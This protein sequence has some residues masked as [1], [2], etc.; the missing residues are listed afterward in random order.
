MR[1]VEKRQAED[2]LRQHYRRERRLAEEPPGRAE[3]VAALAAAEAARAA[4][5]TSRKGGFV[6]AAIKFSPR[7]FWAVPAVVVVLSLV[8]AIA[9][10]SAREAEAALVSSGPVLVAACLVG[11]VR[12]R[13]CRM[14]ELEASCPRNAVSVACARLAILGGATLLA[15]A[16]A[17]A[18]SWAVVPA[19]A[20]MAYALAPYLISAAGGLMLA[21]RVAAA[22]AAV[23]TVAWSAGVC[24]LCLLLRAALPGAYEAGALGMWAAVS[25][26]GAIWLAREAVGWLRLCA[27]GAAA[28]WSAA[29]AGA[30]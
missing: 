8:L 16:F 9:G 15:L 7:A 22:D 5:R 30:L 23:A 12:A 19:G 20:A 17:C 26:A 21:R 24:A 3:V 6:R 18:A 11:V 28:S 25:T 14:Q 4:G 27:E 2:T 13:S 29:R 1:I 10:A